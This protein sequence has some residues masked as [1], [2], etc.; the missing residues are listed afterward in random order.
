MLPFFP[1]PEFLPHACPSDINGGA[2]PPLWFT[3]SCLHECYTKPPHVRPGEHAASGSFL[4][5][6]PPL[7][8]P[9]SQRSTAEDPTLPAASDPLS[10]S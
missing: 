2:F 4:L 5:A 3:I 10:T 8:P 7:S 1:L 9:T 6:P